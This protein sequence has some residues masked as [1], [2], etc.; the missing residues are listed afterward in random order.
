[1][2]IETVN[3]KP[4]RRVTLHDIAHQ[5]GVT[6]GTVSGV[7]RGKTKERRISDE[8]AERVWK[9]AA[10]MDYTPNLLVR[11]LQ[12]GHTHILSFFNGFRSRDKRDAYMDTL[13]TGVER[14]GGSLGYNILMYC[15]FRLDTDETY[16]YINGGHNDGLIFFKPQFDD[17]LLPYLRRSN[18]PVVLVN[19]VDDAGILPSITDDWR[20]GIREIAANLLALGHRRIAAFTGLDEMGD[21]HQRASYL[22]EVLAESGIVV[23]P[24]WVIPGDAKRIADADGTLRFLMNEPE[25]PTALFCWH[26]YLGY[27]V[28]EE[29]ETLG[30]SVPDQLSV[31]G[32]DGIRWP[33]R[34]RHT[35]ASVH[36]DLDGMG[37][38]AVSMLVKLI[39]GEPLA[40]TDEVVPVT[41]DSGTTL[42]APRA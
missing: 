1:M 42:T 24:E 23:P 21:A 16:R 41:F 8:V 18:L 22:C 29:C 12:R 38:G 15:D 4:A 5:A 13:T 6:V 25:P 34:T 9:A 20:A 39:N 26:D 32:Y 27:I 30:I 33:A 11:S 35:L 36:V 17:P 2:N 37:E 14:A 10:D 19:T 7:L 3:L 28:L 40:V 31:V